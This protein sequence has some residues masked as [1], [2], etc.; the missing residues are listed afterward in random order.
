MCL[1]AV[2]R[3]RK[4]V[5]ILSGDTDYMTCKSSDLIYEI[6]YTTCNKECIGDTEQ[7]GFEFINNTSIN[8]KI[9]N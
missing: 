4:V 7:I 9:K 8:C 5:F 3:V 6:I 1:F 2:I